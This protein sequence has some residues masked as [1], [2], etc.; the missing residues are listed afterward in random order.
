MSDPVII[1]DASGSGAPNVSRPQTPEEE[2]QK[3]A[4]Q[5]AAAS[6]VTYVETR[7]V[8]AVVTT[9]DDVPLEVFRFPTKTK[10]VYAASFR[11]TAVDEGNGATKRA[12]AEMTFKGL[13]SSVVQVG[14]TVTTAPMQDAAASSWQ[15]QPSTSGVD[16]IISVKGAAGRTVDWTLAGDIEVFAPGGFA[17]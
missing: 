7:H 12:R 17:S 10:Q 6:R 8:D 14:S 1:I 11:M 16:L 3:A 9:T 4:D 15:I 13:A 5:A 2:A